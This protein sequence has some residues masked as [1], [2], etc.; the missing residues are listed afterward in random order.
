MTQRLRG[1]D[2][3]LQQTVDESGKTTLLDL[4]AS[5][6]EPVDDRMGR[7]E[8]LAL[9]QSGIEEI[10][11]DLNERERELLEDRL[12]ADEPLTL[13]EIGEKYGVTREAVRQ[14]E[15]RLMLKIK[16]ALDARLKRR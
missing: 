3:S 4:E 6:D 7:E 5:D 2:V 15:N 1:R 9:L 12:L 14:M 16:K 10:K 11:D 13:Q 8:M